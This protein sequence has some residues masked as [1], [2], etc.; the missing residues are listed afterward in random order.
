VI[1]KVKGRQCLIVTPSMVRLEVVGD[2]SHFGVTQQIFTYLAR[3]SQG[4]FSM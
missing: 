4:I 3:S 1:F 2:I